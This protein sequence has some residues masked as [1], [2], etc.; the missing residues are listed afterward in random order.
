MYIYGA[1]SSLLGT[2]TVKAD[3]EKDGKT[4]E[5]DKGKLG[6]T[7]RSAVHLVVRVHKPSLA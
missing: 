4:E 5:E 1:V 6:Q 7:S 2:V 3:G